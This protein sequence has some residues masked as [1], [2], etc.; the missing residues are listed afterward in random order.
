MKYGLEY[1]G[2]PDGLDQDLLVDG[3]LR[4]I[5]AVNSDICN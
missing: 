4:D 5:S 1:C 3:S 2:L